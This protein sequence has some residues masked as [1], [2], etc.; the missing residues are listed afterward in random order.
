M[1][2]KKSIFFKW[3]V[4]G[5]GGFDDFGRVPTD[6]SDNAVSVAMALWNVERRVFVVEQF[7]FFRNSDSVVTVR[8]LFRRKFNVVC[9]GS[10]PYRKTILR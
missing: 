7:F 6:S 1:E 9:R 2:Q 4:I 8:R 3:S 10:I 5:K